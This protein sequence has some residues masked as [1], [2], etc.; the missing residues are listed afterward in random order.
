M[1]RLGKVRQVMVMMR[2]VLGLVL[3][4]GIGC[5][6]ASE[7]SGLFEDGGRRGDCYCCCRC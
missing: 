1:L 6:G 4:V 3:H 5:R 7:D 2:R